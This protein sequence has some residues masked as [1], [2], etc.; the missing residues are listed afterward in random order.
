M[1]LRRQLSPRLR[2]GLVLL[3]S[4]V[5]GDEFDRL[6]DTILASLWHDPGTRTHRALNF[7]ELEALPSVLRD[8]RA[9]LVLVQTDQGNRAKLLVSPGLRKVPGDDAKAGSGAHGRAVRGFRR[10][11]A[12]FAAGA[13]PRAHALPWLSARP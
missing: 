7:R 5:R 6:G 11:Q 1:F 4:W 2:S 12:G 10:S 9:A 13:W 3:P 8:S